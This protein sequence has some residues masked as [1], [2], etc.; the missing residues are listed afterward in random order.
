MRRRFSVAFA[1]AVLVAS[2]LFVFAAN[3]AVAPSKTWTS[4]A[5]FSGGTFAATRV[6]GTGPGASIELAIDPTPN[7]VNMAPTVAPS[8]RRG[9]ALTYET[10]HNVVLMF[11]GTL[12]SGTYSN[13]IWTYDTVS[14]VWTNITPG[15]SPPARWRAGFSYDPVEQVAVLFGGADVAGPRADLW[16]FDVNAGTW[17]Q[18]IPTGP[19]PRPLNSN[20]LVYDTVVRKHI[21]V[22]ED[23]LGPATLTWAYDAGT[24]SWENKNPAGPPEA[25][26]GHTLSFDRA[27]GETVLFGGAEGLTVYGD[28]WSY[29][30]TTNT[31]VKDGDYIPNVTPNPRLDHAMIFGPNAANLMFGGVDSASA[32]LPETWVY[33]STGNLWFQPP[34]GTAPGGRRDHGLAWDSATDRVVMFGG[35]LSDGATYTNQTWVWRTGYYNTGNYESPTFDAGCVNV[36]WQDVWWNDTRPATTTVRFKLASSMSPTGP[37]TFYGPDGLPGTFY[38]TVGTAVYPGHDNQQYF[39]WR[40]YETTGDTKVTP[41]MHDFSVNFACPV[42]PPYIVSTSPANGDTGVPVGADIVITFIE[43]MQQ[44]TVLYTFSDP[45]VTFSE[46]WNGASTVLT[47]SHTTPFTECAVQTM[48][49]TAGRDQNDNLDLVAGPV[50]NPWSFTTECVNPFITNTVPADGDTNVGLNQAIIIT[51]SEAIDTGSPGTVTVNPSAD[52]LTPTWSVGDTVLT[53]THAPFTQCTVYTVTVAGFTDLQSLPLVAGPVP[54]PW[55]FTTICPNPYIVSTDPADGATDVPLN[56][57]IVITFSKAMNTASV[58]WTIN[59]AIPHTYTWQPGNQVLVISHTQL[60]AELTLYTVDVTGGT[61]TGGLP[62]VAG[63]VPNPWSFTTVGVNPYIVSTVPAD[64][65]TDVVL[66]ANVVV[67]FSEAMNTASVT[68]TGFTFDGSAW[69]GNTV[70]TLTH[71]TPFAQCTVY[72]LQASGNDL[73]GLPLV[74]GPVPNPWSFTTSC[75]LTGPANLRLSVAGAD[76]QLAWDP[77]LGASSYKV[78]S[79]GNRFATFPSGW[80]LRGSPVVTTF[81]A[82]TDGSDGQRHYYVVRGAAGATEGPNSSMGVKIELAFGHSSTNTNIAWFSLPYNSGYTRASDIATALGST[83]IDVVGKWDPARQ[84][85]VIY[86]YSRGRWRG[87]DFTVNAGDGLYLGVRQ[88]FS[89]TITGTDRSVALSF[90]RNGGTMGNVNW[91]SLPYTGVYQRASDIATELGSTRIT[92][93]G[94]WNAATQSVT[95]YYWTGS[96]WAGTDFTFAPGAGVYVIVASSFTWTPILI[97][98]AVP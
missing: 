35:L 56:S 48:Q 92:E 27:V 28:W 30:A 75:P 62:L 83:N 17:A 61:D 5:D 88:V 95:R 72:T 26:A 10:V 13:E 80:T 69:S 37:F 36:D 18:I 60:F 38:T 45:G 58:T 74:A 67:T 33:I 78:Y 96:T 91:K 63:P 86:Y 64:G 57:D 40:V 50:P 70:L 73:Q 7:W 29:N 90:T 23:P 32:Y 89:W 82:M 46:S 34:V 3:P 11:G 85:S 53:V 31:W 41:S 1:I 42:A 94:L 59:P 47:L 25:R 20:P 68:V 79:A 97:T 16:E 84:S 54:N 98:P 49:I 22:G 77:V 65:A 81:L 87:T 4:D 51:F 55:S 76:V 21:L 9:P 93:V 2:G 66:S 44:G 15:A 24:D 14:N 12:T 19:A 39:R 6:V 43:A 52:P 8:T 71:T